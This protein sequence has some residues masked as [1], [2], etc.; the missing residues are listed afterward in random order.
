MDNNSSFKNILFDLGGV[1]L[2]LNVNGTLES[3]TAQLS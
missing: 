3:G 1:I 2:D